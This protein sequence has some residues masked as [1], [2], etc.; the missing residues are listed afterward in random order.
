[1]NKTAVSAAQLAECF[2]LHALARTTVALSCM[3]TIKNF[4]L[5]T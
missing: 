4:I 2:L 3:R 1:V 5:L